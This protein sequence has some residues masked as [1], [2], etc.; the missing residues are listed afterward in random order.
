MAEVDLQVRQVD[1][2]PPAQFP[3][4]SEDLWDGDKP[5]VD[6]LKEHLKAEGLLH[7]AD[8]KKLLSVA[9]AIFKEEPNLLDLQAP[10]TSTCRP[11]RVSG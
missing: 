3:I 7:E 9:T 4:K 5:R 8:L 2:P 1:V 10:I 11:L 6:V